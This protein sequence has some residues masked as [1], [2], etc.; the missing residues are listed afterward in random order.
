MQC[1]LEDVSKTLPARYR[2]KERPAT[3]TAQNCISNMCLLTEYEKCERFSSVTP[4][5][6]DRLNHQNSHLVHEESHHRPAYPQTEKSRRTES[7]QEEVASTKLLWHMAKGWGKG[8]CCLR[9]WRSA[10]SHINFVEQ[11]ILA[12]HYATVEIF[13]DKFRALH[14]NLCL[15]RLKTRE[16]PATRSL[17]PHACDSRRR[18]RWGHWTIQARRIYESNPWRRMYVTKCNLWLCYAS[19]PCKA[20]WESKLRLQRFTGVEVHS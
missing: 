16:T 5:H 1:T 2:L 17:N 9:A 18:E 4:I 8:R 19:S 13:T 11:K 12:Q 3:L 7:L 15:E 14:L 6:G 20:V 10:S